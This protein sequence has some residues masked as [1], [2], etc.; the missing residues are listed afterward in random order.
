MNQIASAA[1]VNG[2]STGWLFPFVDEIGQR[3]PYNPVKDWMLSKPWDSTDRLQPMYD[4]VVTVEDYPDTLKSTLLYRWLL[5]ATTAAL[6]DGPVPIHGVLTLQGDQGIGKTSWI[7]KLMPPAM[8]KDYIKLDHHLDGADKD[9]ILGCITHFIVELGELD[10]S[11]K[12]DIARIKGFLTNDCD[13]IRRPY[14]REEA[15]Y[16]RKT[17]FAATVNDDRFLVDAT[18]NRRWWTIAVKELEFKHDIDMQQVFAQLAVDFERGEQHWLTPTEAKALGAYNIRHRSVSAIAERVHGY[19]DHEMIGYDGGEVKTAIEVLQDLGIP[20]PSNTQCKECGAVLR[21]LFGPPKR[22]QGRDKWRMHV[23][24]MA[25]II[26]R[27][28]P[29]PEAKY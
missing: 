3:N 17:V 15:E 28:E 8:R 19:I 7:A 21:E 4:T 20:N 1:M 2:M 5:G 11:F 12:K 29:L 10:S 25:N 6:K 13:K 27:A 26:K 16:P 24:P 14:G 9:S 18:G 22:I 23:R